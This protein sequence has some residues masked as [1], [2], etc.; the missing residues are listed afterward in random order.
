MTLR[1]STETHTALNVLAAQ[2]GIPAKK[3]ILDGI[4]DQFARYG[5]TTEVK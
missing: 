5:V 2:H 3:I 4:A 1:L